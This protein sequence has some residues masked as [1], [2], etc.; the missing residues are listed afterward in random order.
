M[1]AVRT[2]VASTVLSSRDAN[3]LAAF[4]Q[5]LLGWDVVDE[6]QGWVKLRPPGGGQALAFHGDERY[7]PPVW[8]TTD[9]DP[10]IMAH[11]DIAVASLDVG[12]AWAVGCGATVA[13]FQP[14]DDVRVL[15]DPEGHPFCLFA[16]EV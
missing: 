12:V 14:Q 2:R 13:D 4:Y 8:P 15:L 1:T 10:P 9:Q 3:A 5:R 6:Q 7:R 11:L 16:G